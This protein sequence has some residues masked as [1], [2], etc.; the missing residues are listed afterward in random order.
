MD[1]RVFK[2]QLAPMNPNNQVNYKLTLNLKELKEIAN[3][4]KELERILE[5]D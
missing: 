5:S 3:L 2:K 4:T 1:F